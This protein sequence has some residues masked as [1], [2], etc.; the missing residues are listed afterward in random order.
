[1]KEM[2]LL[3]VPVND[4]EI[5]L[6]EIKTRLSEGKFSEKLSFDISKVDQSIEIP[7]EMN[8]AAP[9]HTCP[10]TEELID[11]DSKRCHRLN[12]CLMYVIDEAEK[13]LKENPEPQSVVLLFPNPPTR[14][15]NLVSLEK[16]CVC[17]KNDIENVTDTLFVITEL[18][19]ERDEI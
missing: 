8:R 3:F 7:T 18:L 6:S 15:G 5:D 17:V 12:Y 13:L 10:V 19:E 4:V 1:M 11:I 2:S 14:K 9:W 16:G